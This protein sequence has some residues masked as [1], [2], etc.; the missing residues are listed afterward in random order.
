MGVN[1]LIFVKILWITVV[2]K[3]IEVSASNLK[4]AEEQA[5]ELPFVHKVLGASYDREQL[6][7]EGK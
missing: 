4:D 3:I 5:K 1:T 2:P 6:E 7:Q